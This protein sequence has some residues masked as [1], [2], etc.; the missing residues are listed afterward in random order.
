MQCILA[1]GDDWIQVAIK[2]NK[3]AESIN[4]NHHKLGSFKLTINNLKKNDDQLNTN[5]CTICEI[6]LEV[7]K[8]FVTVENICKSDIYI[9]YCM[10]TCT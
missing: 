2:N 7:Y 9:I 8:Y 6:D 10:F 3:M 5:A 4:C 1:S